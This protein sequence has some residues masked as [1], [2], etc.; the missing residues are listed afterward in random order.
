M[1]VIGSEFLFGDTGD[2]AVGFHAWDRARDFPAPI[3]TNLS[4]G[5]APCR[6]IAVPQ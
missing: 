3:E 1:E 2:G 4:V 6:A 5:R